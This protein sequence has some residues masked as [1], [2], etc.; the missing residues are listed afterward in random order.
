MI[1]DALHVIETET[2]DLETIEVVI[3]KIWQKNFDLTDCDIKLRQS[4][5]KVVAEKIYSLIN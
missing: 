2:I 5:L 1:Q 3:S 4:S